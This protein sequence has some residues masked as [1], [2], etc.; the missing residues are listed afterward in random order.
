MNSSRRR[1]KPV[2]TYSIHTY[3]AEEEKLVQQAIENSKRMTRLSPGVREMNIPLA[4]V[5]Y[6]TVEEFAECPLQYIEKIRP[7]AQKYGICKIVPPE[8]WNPPFCE[9]NVYFYLTF[10]FVEKRIGGRGEI[11][12]EL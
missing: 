12:L 5:F 2:H 11:L 3:N 4:P 9:L 8:G 10:Q 7:V 6:P 1:R